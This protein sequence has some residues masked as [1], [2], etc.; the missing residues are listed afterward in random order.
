ME[1]VVH[2]LLAAT[3]GLAVTALLLFAAVAELN[4]QSRCDGRE[5]SLMAFIGQDSGVNHIYLMD[6]DAAGVGSNPVRLTNDG[7]PESYP[8]W[9]P[10]GRRLVY[11]RAFNGSAIYVINADG[12]DQQRLSP[13]PGFDVSPFWSP[14]GAQ[15]VYARLHSPPQPNQPPMTDIRIMNADGTGDHAVLANTVFS[16]EPQWSVK[17]QIVFHEP[18][19]QQLPANLRD[20]HRRDGPPASRFHGQHGQQ[21]RSGVVSGW[22]ANHF[23]I[24]SRGRK[25]AQRLHHEHGWQPGAA[26]DLF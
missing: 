13:T 15:I 19:E 21:W 22:D 3:A 24:R 9:S 4:A 16:V 20:E 6:V 23:R 7:E 26:V 14:D 12:T 10:D 18:D 1:R 11:Q 17:G 8:F 2:S 5:T 25:P